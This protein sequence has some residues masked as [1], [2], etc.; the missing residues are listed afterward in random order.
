MKLSYMIW[1]SLT[2]KQRRWCLKYL[3]ALPAV[4]FFVLAIISAAVTS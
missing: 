4:V 1:T 3:V 2:I